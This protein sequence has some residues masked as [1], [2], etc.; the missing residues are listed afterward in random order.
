[1]EFMDG[2]D[3]TEVIRVCREEITDGNMALIL[4]EVRCNGVSP[5]CGHVSLRGHQTLLA[6][7]YLHTRDDPIIH[8]DV[9]SDNILLSLDGRVKISACSHVLLVHMPSLAKACVR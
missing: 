5:Y 4:R 1:M 7:N 3:L 8:R 2:G 6:L 9:K